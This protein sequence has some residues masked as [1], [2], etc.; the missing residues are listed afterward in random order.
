MLQFVPLFF[1]PTL[2][3]IFFCHFQLF[4]VETRNTIF[5]SIPSSLTFAKERLLDADSI[6]SH[7]P[8]VHFNSSH[9]ADGKLLAELQ[10]VQDVVSTVSKT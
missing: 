4:N 10:T 9:E 8:S 3:T 6:V 5:Q 2:S 7:H 1:F